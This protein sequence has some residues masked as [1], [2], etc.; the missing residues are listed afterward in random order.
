MIYAFDGF[1]PVVHETAFV[2]PQAAVTGNV[3]IGRDVYVGP[4]A[5]IRGDWGGIVIEDGCNVQENCTMHMFPGVMVVLEAGAHIGH[6][7]IVH[8]ARIGA[9]AL[10]GM[11]AVIMDNAVVGAG[12]VVGA[13]C[14]VPTGMEIPPRKVVVGNPAQDREGR[15][16]RDAR[17]EDG[18]HRA[19]SAAAGGDARVVAARW[20]RCAKCPPIDRRSRR[21]SRTG[22]IRRRDRRNALTDRV[23][24]TTHHAD[25]ENYATDGEWVRRA[26]GAG[27]ADLIHA[28]TG[29]TIGE[30]GSGGLDFKA[31]PEYARTVGG[32]ALRALTFHQRAR[33]AQGARQVPDGAQG[34][35][36]RAVE[37][38]RRHQGRQLGR[39][40]RRHRHVLR[41]LQPRTPRAPQRDVSRGRTARSRC[42]RAAPSSAAT[43]ACRWK[44][45]RCTSTPSTSRSG[46]CW[47]SWRRHCWPACRAS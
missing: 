1:I 37:R 18:R 40:R 14:F 15:D 47:R 21:C 6:G 19:V 24:D 22:R 35:V 31:M 8:G 7:A 5:A 23:C 45:W 33:D 29:E 25:V 27:T 26:P 43:S 17:V 10:V 44:A 36:L 28:V 2:H 46:A 20:S 4:G 32:P 38:H 3:I 34:R 42:P 16:R 30:A 41:V 9:N 11:N 39:H 12:C 13:L